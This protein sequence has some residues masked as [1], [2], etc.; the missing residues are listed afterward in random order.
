M[1]RSF[2]AAASFPAVCDF[3]VFPAALVFHHFHM[4]RVLPR[5]EGQH[6]VH[7]QAPGYLVGNEEH[8]GLALEAIDGFG[9]TFRGV[10]V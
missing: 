9:E 2:P 8:G 4:R 3:I 10:V 6:F 5:P 1:L 7:L